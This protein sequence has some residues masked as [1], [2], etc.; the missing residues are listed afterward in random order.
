MCGYE[1]RCGVA[2]RTKVG[3][4]CPRCNGKVR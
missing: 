3:T 2:N 4:G 1:W